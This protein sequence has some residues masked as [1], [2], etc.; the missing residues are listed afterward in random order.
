MSDTIRQQAL[1][2][3]VTTLATIGVGSGYQTNAG[4]N[5]R[6][7]PDRANQPLG[8]QV[9]TAI[10][11]RDTGGN[12]VA[13]M[14]GENFGVIEIELV[15][16]ARGTASVEVDQICRRITGDINRAVGVDKTLGSLVDDFIFGEASFEAGQ[17]KERIGTMTTRARIHYR[18]ERFA[19]FTT[20]T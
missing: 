9:E 17:G 3:L 6:L 14:V 16:Q 20:A 11:V 19:P 1:T 8:A 7:D 12:E 2:A 5:V 10:T 18:T 13:G 15:A 4:S